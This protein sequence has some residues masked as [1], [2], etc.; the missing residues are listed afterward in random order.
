ATPLTAADIAA[1]DT[2]GNGVIDTG[3]DPYTP[4]YPGNEYVDWWGASMYWKGDTITINSASPSGYISTQLN[5]VL[6]GNVSSYQFAKQRNLPIIFPEMAGSYC[7]QNNGSTNLQTKQQFWRDVFGPAT[8]AEFPLLKMALWFDYSK[9]ED[10]AQR[11]FTISNLNNTLPDGKS[12]LNLVGPYFK[13][14]LANYSS[15]IYSTNLMMSGSGNCGCF[16]YSATGSATLNN[17]NSGTS[18]G[19]SESGTTFQTNAAADVFTSG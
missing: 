3:D 16:R 6:G 12:S 7:A 17:V 18:G 15:V 2:N 8:R 19:S 10:N 11:D 9:F 4:Y 13:S 14:D 5:E 1:A